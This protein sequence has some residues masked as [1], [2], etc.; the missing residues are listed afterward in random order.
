M[1]VVELNLM[2]ADMLGQKRVAL[3]VGEGISLEGLAARLKLPYEDMGMLLI[4]K[5]WAPLE[6]STIRDGDVVQ[7]YPYMDGG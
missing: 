6:G 7:L 1:I 3:D 5:Q 4:N 2:F